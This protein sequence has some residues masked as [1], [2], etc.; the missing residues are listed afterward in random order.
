[1]FSQS[2]L[3]AAWRD[4]AAPPDSSASTQE[5]TTPGLSPVSEESAA[6]NCCCPAVSRV[7]A[8]AGSDDAEAD[9]AVVPSSPLP[10]S[11]SD[12]AVVP[13]SSALLAPVPSALLASEPNCELVSPAAVVP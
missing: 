9:V 11:T 13:L 4:C 10:P 3:P 8:P 7:P 1:M 6:A 2:L 5:D 12:A